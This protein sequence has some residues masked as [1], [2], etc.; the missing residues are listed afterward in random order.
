MEATYTRDQA[1]SRSSRVV[2]LQRSLNVA[3]CT[4]TTIVVLLCILVC[5]ASPS[6]ACTTV[7]AVSPDVEDRDC[8]SV[9]NA[10]G[11]TVYDCIE[12]SDFLTQLDGCCHNVLTLVPKAIYTLHH[13]N[14][15]I[16]TSLTMTSNDSSTT[17]RCRVSDGDQNDNITKQIF[18][19]ANITRRNES[20]LLSGV[21]FENCSYS[22]RFNYLN[23]LK[24]SNCIF[25][26]M[27]ACIIHYLSCFLIKALQDNTI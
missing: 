25:R 8:V 7:Y 26:Y 23:Q 24:I 5:A 20:V 27:N 6:A 2:T 18:F 16:T 4:P 22:L 9:T 3:T 12:F 21:T 15:S 17:I 13:V 1:S 14:I 11:G 19:G 10:T